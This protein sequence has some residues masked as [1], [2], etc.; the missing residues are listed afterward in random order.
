[1]EARAHWLG[2]IASLFLL[3]CGG[4]ETSSSAADNGNGNGGDGTGAGAAGGNENSGGAGTG[5]QGG[6]ASGGSGGDTLG[7]YPGG[8]YGAQEG[9]TIENLLWEGYVNEEAQALANTQPFVDYS[10]DAVRQSGKALAFVHFG[11][12][13]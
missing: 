5:A 13:F 12:V 11:A 3:A 7:A 4:E 1:M 2:G 6:S 9:D 10:M 8:P